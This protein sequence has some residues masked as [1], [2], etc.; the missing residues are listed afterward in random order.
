MRLRYLVGP[1]RREAAHDCWGQV[2]A[3]G[4]CR[5]FNARG[6]VDLAVAPDDAWETICRR[7]PDDGRPDGVVLLLADASVPPALWLA[8]VPLIGLAADADRHWHLYRRLL[9]RCDLVFTDEAGRTAMCRCGWDHGRTAPPAAAGVLEAIEGEWSTLRANAQRRIPANP[10]RATLA[11]MWSRPSPGG[12]HSHGDPIQDLLTRTWQALLASPQTDETLSADLAAAVA[13]Q[14]RA[15][16]L[17][18]ALGVLASLPRTGESL[19]E[20]ESIQRAAE[21]FRA[22]VACEPEHPI[23]ILN[24]VEALAALGEGRLAVEGAQR[25]LA[26]LDRG[27]TWPCDVLDAPLGTPARGLFGGEWEHAAFRNAGDAHAEEVAKRALLRWRLHGLLASLTGELL[28]LYEAVVARPDLASSRAALGKELLG[29]GQTRAAV[30]HLHHAAQANPLD[31]EVARALSGALAAVGDTDALHRFE[32]QRR[33]LALAAGALPSELPEPASPTA[34]ITTGARGGRGVSLCLIVKNEEHNLPACLAAASGLVDE[35]I[36]VDTGSTDRTREVA[37]RQGARLFDFPWCDSFSAARN[38]CLR[39]ASGEWIFWLDADDRVDEDNRHKL[40]ALFATLPEGNVA[41]VMKCLCLPDAVSGA[42]TAVDHIRLF[43]RHPR[44]CWRYRVH[45]QILPALRESGAEV[46]WTDI[47]IHHAGYQDPALRKRKLERDLRLLLLE[48]RERPGD[49]F[50]LFNLGSIYHEQGRFDEALPR[51]RRSLERSRSADSIVRKLY[52]LIVSCHRAR[53]RRE[54]AWAA[55]Q[56]GL[57]T[58]PDDTE[59]LFLHS[60]MCRE[61]GDRTGAKTVLTRLL[62]DKSPEY[63]ASVDAGLRGYKARHN[64][65]VMH[66]EDGELSEAERHWRAAV[67]ERPDFLPA[68]LG[69]GDVCLRRGDWEGVEE[70]AGR[71]ASLSAGAAESAVLRARGLAAQGRFA[72]ARRLLTEAV[73]R[74]PESPGPRLVLSHVLLQ[75]GRDLDAAERALRDVLELVPDHREAR[76]NLDLLLRSREQVRSPTGVSQA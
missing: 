58:C 14:P 31:E 39:H 28:H 18:N 40:R 34:A 76:H 50:I 63:F 54:Q 5:A 62:N 45:E 43:R 1:L 66:V 8:P 16:A 26:L 13:R 2:R 35:I 38:E 46:R 60:S 10:V 20:A 21:H 12:H 23:A 3:D 37:A 6:D 33:L 67:A 64:L 72:E 42:A 36:V 52:A 53:G 44:V 29:R 17:H 7:W 74:W 68:W 41:Y 56:E 75:E 4:L 70:V 61:A 73:A 71:M 69:L 55:C 9:P 51:L 30:P 15:A 19:A 49:P 59:L 11:P 47:V 32:H 48:D 25:L 57:R 27:P 22:A 24:L 65:A